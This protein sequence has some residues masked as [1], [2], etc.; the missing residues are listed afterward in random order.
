MSQK[1]LFLPHYRSCPFNLQ[2]VNFQIFERL[3]WIEENGM[4]VSMAFCRYAFNNES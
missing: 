1:K 3:H 4:Q 2:D